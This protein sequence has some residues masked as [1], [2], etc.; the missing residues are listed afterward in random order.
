MIDREQTTTRL[1]RILGLLREDLADERNDDR[2]SLENTERHLTRLVDALN[3]TSDA[4]DL[5]AGLTVFVDVLTS[6]IANDCEACGGCTAG[7]DC[8][9]NLILADHKACTCKLAASA[10]YGKN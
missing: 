8:I 5:V 10:T 7:P 9:G 6:R 1:T 4:A 2:R 3:D